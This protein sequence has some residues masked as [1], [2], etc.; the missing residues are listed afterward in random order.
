M[1]FPHSTVVY[2][3]QGHRRFCVLGIPT[4]ASSFD[5]LCR[6]SAFSLGWPRADL[7]TV[8]SKLWGTDHVGL[9][10]SRVEE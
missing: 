1:P 8:V 9:E 2:R 3:G 5:P 10:V 7:P 6:G 4:S